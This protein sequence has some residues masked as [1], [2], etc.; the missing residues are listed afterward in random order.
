MIKQAINSWLLVLAVLS[1]GISHS[2]QAQEEGKTKSMEFFGFIMMDAGYNINQIDPSWFDVMRPTKLPSF[3]NEFG[4]NGNFF[5]SV[6]QTRLGLKNYFKTPLGVLKTF[7]EIDMFGTGPDA[8]KTTMRLRH[9]YAELGKLSIGQSHSPFMDINVF[10]NTLDYWG[11]NGM[12]FF[13]NVQ[14]RYQP[15]QGDTYL[16]FALEKP[17]ASADQGIY[18]DRVELE[19]VYMRFPVPDFS[20]E[21]HR[22]TNFGY[23]ELAGIVRSIKWEDKNNDLYDLSGN[24]LGWGLNL[25]TNVNLTKNDIFRGQLV[26]GEGIQ[27]YFND[28]PVDISLKNIPENIISP[29]KGVALPIVGAVAFLDHSWNEKFSSAIGYSLVSIKNTDG[30]AY[31]AFKKGQYISANLLYYPVKNMMAGIELQWFDRENYRDGWSTSAT[32]IQCSFR[33]NFSQE[34]K[35]N[36]N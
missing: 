5:F 27:N 3:T 9:A 25:S 1:V 28:A 35:E 21:Y 24:A 32:K 7:F 18:S 17:G 20:F 36:L 14:I 4:T 30:Q 2:L 15:I 16:S 13:R 19:G 6:R 12:V 10:P 34:F 31:N 29:V 23:V 33:F 22:N 11:P 26:Y 8:G